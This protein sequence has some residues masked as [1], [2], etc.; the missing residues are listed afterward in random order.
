MRMEMLL[1]ATRIG[2]AFGV[3]A[4]GGCAS[5]SSVNVPGDKPVR[6]MT[7]RQV[8]NDV[9][10]AID[11][12]SGRGCERL[13]AKDKAVRCS[14]TLTAD[15]QIQLPPTAEPLAASNG[16]L[17]FYAVRRDYLVVF[18]L[19]CWGRVGF[20]PFTKAASCLFPN[21]VRRYR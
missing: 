15:T 9:D 14:Y 10:Q 17:N 12:G 3:M 4:I 2:F 18:Q 13:T 5:T 19:G 6:M 11:R 20:D 7:A 21:I 8:L 16:A 1:S